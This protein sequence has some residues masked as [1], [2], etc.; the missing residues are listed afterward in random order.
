M[1]EEFDLT[2]ESKELGYGG[3]KTVI[4]Y[5]SKAVI[6]PNDVDG[7]S[8]RRL[9]PRIIDDEI[10]MAAYLASIGIPTLSFHRCRVHCKDY[11]LE[12]IY[13]TPFSEFA[14]QGTYIVDTKNPKSTIWSRKFPG[15]TLFP[16]GV[17]KYEP[18]SWLPLL[19]PLIGDIKVVCKNKVNLG[20]DALNLAFVKKGSPWHSG[21]ELP[22]EVRLFCFDL[23]S[24]RG[25]LKI[26]TA[27]EP[28]FERLLERVIESCVWEEICPNSMSMTEPARQLRDE[29]C[30]LLNSR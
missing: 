15:I 20:I 17:D 19:Q 16:E 24:K 9:W 10:T 22:F 25:P 21:D 13:T 18:R 4:E 1:V 23:S 27:D 26:H 5:D 7:E 29:L 11:D 2:N 3:T 8:L 14:S 12:T 30:K 6:L 28:S